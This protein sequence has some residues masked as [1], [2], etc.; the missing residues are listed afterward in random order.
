MRPL[1]S[2]FVFFILC[3]TA[4]SAD[5]PAV[6]E[7]S[8]SNNQPTSSESTGPALVDLASVCPGLIIDLRYATE[9]NFTH[10]K[11]YPSNSAY[12]V[13]AAAEALSRVH[14]ALQQQGFGLKVWDAY[15]P[16]S[17]Q[18]K[19]GNLLPDPKFVAPPSRG[20]RHNRAASVD[21]TLVDRH[22]QEIPMPTEFDD[23]SKKAAAHNQD[24]SNE[25]KAHRRILQ[26][27]MVR[28]G[29]QI[30]ET[31]WWHFDFQHWKECPLLDIEFPHPASPQAP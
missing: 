14:G 9:D 18:K 6:P 23:F 16:L 5:V 17:I 7:R 29:F 22:G 10:T 4:S 12:L 15:R 11:L 13:P 2:V 3:Q 24:C 20:S 1:F 27:A 30:L 28:E 21:V 8:T 31:E 25:A 19:F 26:E